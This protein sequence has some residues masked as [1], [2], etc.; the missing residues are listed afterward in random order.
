MKTIQENTGEGRLCQNLQS[1][2]I[3][4][5][6]YTEGLQKGTNFCPTFKNR[7]ARLDFARENLKKPPNFWEAYQIILI[8]QTLINL[9]R[10]E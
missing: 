6:V 9:H 4:I 3:F 1:R 7:K 5:N 8:D 2:D 10:I